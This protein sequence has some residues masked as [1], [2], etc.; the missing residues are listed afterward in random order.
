MHKTLDKVW[1]GQDL[2]QQQAVFVTSCKVFAPQVLTFVKQFCQVCLSL[3]LAVQN[4]ASS[5]Q[6][7][8]CCM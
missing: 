4:A 2:A 5:D 7:L 3:R 6:F 1:G 8:A